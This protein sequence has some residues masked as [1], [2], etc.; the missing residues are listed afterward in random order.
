MLTG[1]FGFRLKYKSRSLLDAAIERY[2]GNGIY[3]LKGPRSQKDKHALIIYSA[4]AVSKHLS[5]TLDSFPAIHTHS[6]FRESIELLNRVLDLGYTVDYFSYKKPPAIQWSKYQLVIDSSNNLEH[7][8]EVAGQKR[9]YYATTCHWRLFQHN[10]YKHADS[11]YKRNKILLYPDREL[12][13]NYSDEAADIITCFGGSYQANSFGPNKN[14][15]R[16]LT[17]S[18]THLPEPGFKKVTGAKNKFMW[19]AGY[20]SFHKGFDLVVEAFLKMPDMELHIFSH[21]ESQPRLY[22]WF[23]QITRDAKNIRY[24]GWAAPDSALFKNYAQLCDAV[25]FA[26]TSEGGAGAIIQCMQFG[27]IPIINVST[28]IDLA[29]NKFNIT[30]NDPEEEITSII[31]KV[32]AFSKSETEELQQYAHELN[33]QYSQQHTLEHYSESLKNVIEHL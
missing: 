25:V 22:H 29:N 31:D 16:Q 2:G 19:F 32:T 11:F 1:N 26:S 8:R 21:I 4:E 24:H 28:G 33:Q 20:G 13:N 14:K 12:I 18:T 3:D 10:A 7:A 17:I 5:G 6:G 30:G 9:I 23:L 27:L 15:V